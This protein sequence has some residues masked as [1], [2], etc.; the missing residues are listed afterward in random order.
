MPVFT[1]SDYT[2]ELPPKHTFPME[3]YEAVPRHLEAALR[4]SSPR[5]PLQ[6]L[7]APR[8]ATLAEVE[9]AHDPDYVARF[10]AATTAALA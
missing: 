3:R 2:L 9:L 7:R 8:L 10:V 5:P 6:I 4:S 1:H